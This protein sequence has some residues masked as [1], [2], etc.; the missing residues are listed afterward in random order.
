[1]NEGHASGA[2]VT[3]RTALR[4]AA[5]LAAERAVDVLSVGI[6][7]RPQ[8]AEAAAGTVSFTLN[9]RRRT[10][11]VGDPS[12]P[13]LYV[14]R[15][16]FGL[17]GPK[18]GCG[19]QQ[20]GACSVLFNGASI[21]SCGMPVAAVAGA[22]LTTIE[23]L[24]DEHKPHPLQT[25][26]IEEQAAQ[27][28]YCTSG[29]IV[30]AASLLL[31]SPHPTD[32]E[33][34]A[35]LTGNLCRCGTHLRILRAVRRA[36]GRAT[37]ETGT[38]LTIGGVGPSAPAPGVVDPLLSGAG[39]STVD[40]W[41]SIDGK[42]V[43]TVYSGKVEQ[44]TGTDTALLQLVADELAVPFERL[45]IVEG[46]TGR[47]PDQGVTSGSATIQSGSIPMRQAAATAR[48]RLVTLAAERLK[49]P[50]AELTAR[51]GYV[52]PRNG[53]RSRALP[54]GDL[55]GQRTFGVQID[56]NIPL[57]GAGGFRVVGKPLKRIDLRR[58]RLGRSRTCT[59]FAYRECGTPA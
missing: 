7:P 11:A 30:S 17:T 21:R 3:R 25:A 18:F 46:I 12:E 56:P 58:R 15:D 55:I 36:A 38:T 26:F 39:S 32:D 23:G 1:M 54:Y 43:V 27:C 10:V 59:T 51:D 57:T 45:R 4:V 29:M 19:L 48:T 52:V 35:A 42:G 33:I 14:L 9:G 53:D 40:A 2:G 47:T 8:P 6:G 28:G 20:C 44:G 22:T 13:L 24:G 50:A 41:L 31:R 34:S 5:L 37:A 49:M 16:Q